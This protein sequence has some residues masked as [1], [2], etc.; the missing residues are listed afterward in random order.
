MERPI[1]HRVFQVAWRALAVLAGIFSAL[2][3]SD[4]WREGDIAKATNYAIARWK[5]PYTPSIETAQ[6]A[7][8]WQGASVA[9]AIIGIISGSVMLVRPYA[10]ELF[11][12][13]PLAKGD[14]SDT[15]RMTLWTV[16]AGLGGVYL[17]FNAPSMAFKDWWGFVLVMW[18]T[19]GLIF[20]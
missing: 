13:Q 8:F 3:A 1:S 20:K 14:R 19:A 17:L 7:G 9:C 12:F 11:S 4:A 2:G 6:A 5:Q 10:R 16:Q 18:I 15:W